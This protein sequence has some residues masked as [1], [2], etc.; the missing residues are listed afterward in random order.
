MKVT[1]ARAM[2]EKNRFIGRISELEAKINQYNEYQN[3]DED[4]R[5]QLKMGETKVDIS[6]EYS[7]RIKC[8]YILAELKSVIAEANA[9]HGIS[10]IIY[11]MEELKSL[12][13]FL[14]SIPMRT[15]VD[16]YQLGP[17]KM[18]FVR[19]DTQITKNDIET[20]YKDTQKEI[21]YYQDKIDELNATVYVEIPDL[22]EI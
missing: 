20:L 8:S 14:R 12:I 21:E 16:H 4:I 9:K 11:K 13:R 17:E 2:K 18:V 7:L 19:T 10:N 3:P 6:T 1:L 5:E 22:P 15:R